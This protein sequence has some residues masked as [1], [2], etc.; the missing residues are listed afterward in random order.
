M[1][2]HH[3]AVHRRSENLVEPERLHK[4]LS[5]LVSL[6]LALNIMS[7]GEYKCRCRMAVSSSSPTE[8][9]AHALFAD[10]VHLELEQT[11]YE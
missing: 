2:S 9:F 11:E 8:S 7:T 1:L 4:L 6:S 10:K 3:G 5:M